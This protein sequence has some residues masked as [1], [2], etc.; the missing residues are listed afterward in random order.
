MSGVSGPRLSTVPFKNLNS[1]SFDGIDELLYWYKHLF[2]TKWNKLKQ[3]WS[4]W[5]KPNFGAPVYGFI[6]SSGQVRHS[7]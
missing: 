1:F 4:Y 2:R 7:T 5:V 3:L 6:A